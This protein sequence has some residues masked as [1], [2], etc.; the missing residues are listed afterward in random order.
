MKRLS[1]SDAMLLVRLPQ[2]GY[3][4]MSVESYRRAGRFAKVVT[5]LA[6][7]PSEHEDEIK[8]L[9]PR[10]GVDTLPVASWRPL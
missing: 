6:I 2:M 5:V 3:G 8:G 4:V 9:L 1:K 10:R 7:F